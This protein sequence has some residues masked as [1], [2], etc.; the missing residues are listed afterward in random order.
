M[1]ENENNESKETAEVA[2]TLGDVPQSEVDKVIAENGNQPAEEYKDLTGEESKAEEKFQEEL[3]KPTENPQ[4]VQ[5][6]VEA[7]PAEASPVAQPSVNLGGQ[8]GSVPLDNQ[9]V[10]Q[11]EVQPA[12]LV[13]KPIGMKLLQ[14]ECEA[15][16]FKVYVNIEDDKI[17]ELPTKLKC[18][19]CAKKKSSKRRIFDMTL[20]SAVNYVEPDADPVA[21]PEVSTQ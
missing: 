6:P 5:Q 15:C 4:Q 20:N 13:Q 8:S 17:E 1:D 18:M 10:A 12:N 21:Q 19:N 2:A 9:P 7:A 11:P 16:Q 3:A 14:F